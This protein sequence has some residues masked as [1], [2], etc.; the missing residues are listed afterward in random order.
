MSHK[1]PQVRIFTFL[2][3]F[4]LCIPCIAL[5]QESGTSPDR[6]FI[7]LDTT[8]RLEFEDA[9]AFIV[10]N[11]GVSKTIFHPPHV[12]ID[13]IPRKVAHDLVGQEVDAS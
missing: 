6:A 10:E 4:L 5:A 8:N 13:E 1:F 3:G 9:A 7:I 12:I 11:S 2:A